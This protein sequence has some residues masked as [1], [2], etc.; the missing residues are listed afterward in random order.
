M[1]GNS[2]D[3]DATGMRD[4]HKGKKGSGSKDEVARGF[5]QLWAD[6][7]VNSPPRILSTGKRGCVQPR[8]LVPS[9][10]NGRFA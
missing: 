10:V 5:I 9:T 2:T 6:Y 3:E 4:H 8:Q 7:S 1:T